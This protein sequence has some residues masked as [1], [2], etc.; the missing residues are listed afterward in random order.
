MAKYTVNFPEGKKFTGSYLSV[1]FAG[2]EGHT[3][4]DY[5]AERFRDKGLT[6]T[7]NEPAGAEKQLEDMTAAE[8]KAY[9]KEHEIDLGDATKKPDILAAIQAAEAEKKE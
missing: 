4:S 5:L 2:G 1:L 9:A 3:D 7:E 6:I 8:L